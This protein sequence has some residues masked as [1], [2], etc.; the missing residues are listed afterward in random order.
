MAKLVAIAA[1]TLIF[2][3]FACS[4]SASGNNCYYIQVGTFSEKQN[5]IRLVKKYTKFNEKVVI[6][7]IRRSSSGTMF[8][9]IVGPFASWK[10]ADSHRLVLRKKGI[11]LEDAFIKKIN[12]FTLCNLSE[13]K[14]AQPFYYK[15]DIADQKPEDKAVPPKQVRPIGSPLDEGRVPEQT[16]PPKEMSQKLP[17]TFPTLKPSEIV[18]KTDHKKVGRNTSKN[19]FS[20][21]FA[22]TYSE[23]QTKLD[24]RQLTI[25]SGGST[26]TVNI[27]ANSLSDQDY[28]TSF[29]RDTVGLH[30]G[31]ADYLE[32]FTDIGVAYQDLSNL[33]LTYGIGGR[34]NIFTFYR[35]N[36]DQ[37]YAAVLGE[38]LFGRIEYEYDSEAGT[39]WYKD[40]DWQYLSGRCE[41]GA[42]FS[43]F[44]LYAGGTYN[45][46]SEKSENS[47]MDDLPASA[48]EYKYDDELTGDP[49]LGGFIGGAYHV[50]KKLHINLEGQAGNPNELAGSLKYDF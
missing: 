36:G 21:S 28:Y 43:K 37:Y 7:E 44:S 10:E 9:V 6:N 35:P 23:F 25:S 33:N 27:D 34:L 50:T 39:R 29:H 47:L 5:V 31:V 11:Y 3:F 46:Y 42:V 32:I 48:T 2:L 19:R 17:E 13:H 14:T 22:H 8:Q 26:T 30:Y 16:T 4:V 38:A 15:T 41:I 1:P 45:H 20:I 40:G 49:K 24:E 18:G 12:N